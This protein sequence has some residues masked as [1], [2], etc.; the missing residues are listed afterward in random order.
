MLPGEAM[1]RKGGNPRS[2]EKDSSRYKNMTFKNL[3][4]ILE[5]RRSHL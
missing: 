3:N 2:N 1:R 4:T 5:D